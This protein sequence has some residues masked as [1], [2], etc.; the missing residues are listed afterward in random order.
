MDY[1]DKFVVNCGKDWGLINLV[2]NI[3]LPGVGTIIS[4]FQQDGELN[5]GALIIGILQ[6]VLAWMVIGWIWSIIHGAL[7]YKKSE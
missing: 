4:S 2:L 1:Y 7:I 5:L 3:V 6:L